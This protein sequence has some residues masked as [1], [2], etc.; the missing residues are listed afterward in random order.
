MPWEVKACRGRNAQRV[1]AITVLAVYVQKLCNK[2]S[3]DRPYQILAG[4]LLKEDR[5]SPKSFYIIY[6]YLAFNPYFLSR[7]I[8]SI[9]IVVVACH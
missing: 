3:G 9:E 6:F 7:I 8:P 1:E 5:N 2:C 4:K